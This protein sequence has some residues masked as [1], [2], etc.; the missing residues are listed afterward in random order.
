MALYHKSSLQFQM[1][2]SSSLSSLH[3]KVIFLEIGVNGPVQL[4]V[5]KLPTHQLYYQI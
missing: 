1:S 3:S 5:T 2:M 4:R